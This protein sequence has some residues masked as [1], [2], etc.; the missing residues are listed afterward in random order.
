MF[1]IIDENKQIVTEKSQIVGTFRTHF[2]I[3]NIKMLIKL[4]CHDNNFN[5]HT[6]KIYNK[7]HSNFFQSADEIL[8][9]QKLTKC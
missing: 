9:H 7:I 5:M 8:K 4:K 2:S 3:V 1:Q 6:T